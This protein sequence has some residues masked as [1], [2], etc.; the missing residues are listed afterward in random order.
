MTFGGSLIATSA[1]VSGT[2]TSTSATFGTVLVDA[3]GVYVNPPTGFASSYGYKFKYD[4][5]VAA[6]LFAAWT[7]GSNGRLWLLNNKPD[8]TTGI[9]DTA[10]DSTITIGGAAGSAK[11]SAVD[12]RAE[13]IVGGVAQFTGLS[14]LNTSSARKATIHADTFV[15]SPA[16]GGEYAVW[17]AGNGGPGS[18]L[19]ADTVDGKHAADFAWVNGS[20][21]FGYETT[22]SN[23]VNFGTYLRLSPLAT[24]PAYQSDY[25]LIYLLNAGSNAY[26]LRVKIRSADGTRS[27]DHQIATT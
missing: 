23:A 11:V 24:A 9:V 25:A 26:Q 13:R 17:H 7:S 6:G 10:A 20:N 22:F 3:G 21:T 14:L 4:T 2:F 5:T 27:I 16:A 18:G 15:V 1:T 12:L 8:A 19:N